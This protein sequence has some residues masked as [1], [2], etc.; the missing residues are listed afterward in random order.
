MKNRLTAQPSREAGSNPI[1]SLFPT[2][3]QEPQR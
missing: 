2:P 3:T 1:P